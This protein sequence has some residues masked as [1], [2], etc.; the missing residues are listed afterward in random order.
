MPTL[1]IDRARFAVTM[2]PER[3]IVRD[4]SILVEGG[5]IA[6]LGPA[7]ALAGRSADRVIDARE[8]VATPGL[9][10]NHMH[11][12][13]AH[14]VR[15]I[16]PDALDPGVY[17]A[18]VFA[19]QA[20]M[21]EEDE[22]H[23]SLLAICELL[24]YGTTCFLDP[25]STKFLDAC[26]DA[27]GRAGCRIV[28]GAQ[29][30]DQPNPINLP[31]MATGDALG[32]VEDTI[33]RFDGR[34]DGRVRAWAM[35]FSGDYATDELLRGAKRLADHHG[36][37]LT[38]HQANSPASVRASLERHG[39]R[40]IVRLAELGVLGPNVLLAHVIDLSGEELDAMARTGTR[41]VMAPPAALKMGTGMTRLAKLP[42]MLARGIPV[43][44]A[45]DAGNNSN[46]LDTHRAM[47][48]AAVLYKDARRTTA[49]VP[50]ETALEL[51]TINGAVALGLER[52]IGSLEVGKQ[53]DLVLY[54][55][56][57]PEWRG[58]FNPVNALV[59]A[60]DGRSVHTVLIDG[61][62]VVEAGR[63]TFVDE[64][65]LIDRV[66]EIGE[67]LLARTGVGFDPPW[68]VI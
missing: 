7:A 65:A 64:G 38:L 44:L 63:P 6:A 61:R 42:E 60:A 33:R 9:I 36:T 29:V 40:P 37:G 23:T 49:V 27:Y 68:P 39:K 12:S 35:P 22:Y 54:D 2:D 24:R 32:R 20:A 34:L 55:T 14:A 45:T 16:F 11:V 43:S 46:L 52:R 56:R 31:V 4:A 66:Q 26:L 58:L 47:Y 19:L 5:R 15:G 62:V 59:Y 21:T 13:Y 10:N 1:L 18:N 67:R 28:V 8:M 30:V 3:R 51:A 50:A 57:R 41:A 48:L 17:L 25:G 53:A